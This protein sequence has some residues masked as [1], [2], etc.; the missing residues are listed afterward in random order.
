MYSLSPNFMLGLDPLFRVC[1]N[2]KNKVSDIFSTY[3]GEVDL[4]LAGLDA[5]KANVINLGHGVNK[6]IR[7]IEVLETNIKKRICLVK[8][9]CLLVLSPRPYLST[10]GDLN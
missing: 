8:D 10:R 1:V 4:T 7:K 3:I 5:L 9:G 6:P 2:D